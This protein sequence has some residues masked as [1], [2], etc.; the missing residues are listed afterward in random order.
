M[1][2]IAKTIEKLREKRLRIATAESCTGGL[3]AAAIT[4]IPG[5]SDA[6]DCGIICYSN[7][8]KEKLLAVDHQ[9]LEEYGAVSKETAIAMATGVRKLA[10]ADIALAITGIAGPSGGTAEKPVGLVYIALADK[11]HCRA[12]KNIFP[13]SRDDV[14]RQSVE[15][16]LKMLDELLDNK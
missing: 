9:L 11:E 14:R 6:F 10:K 1:S 7:E 4:A 15:Q 13:G 2:D 16:A 12:I 3:V 8:I 5:A